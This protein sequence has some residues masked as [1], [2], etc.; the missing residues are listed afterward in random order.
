MV[1]E[2]GHRLYVKGRHISHARGKRNSTPSVSL[3]QIE[4]VSDTAGANFYLGKKVA[5]VYRASKEIRGS[6]IRVIWG[7]IARTHGNSGV[8]RAKFR[9]NLPPKSFGASVRIMLYPSSI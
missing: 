8:V 2:A 1:S 5:F 7:T 3:I 9:N 6:K 4:G